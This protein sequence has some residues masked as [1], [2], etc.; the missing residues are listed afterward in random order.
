MVQFHHGGWVG[1]SF[2][3]VG[4][5]KRTYVGFMFIGGR[6]PTYVGFLLESTRKGQLIP[7]AVV[8][9]IWRSRIFHSNFFPLENP[10]PSDNQ[11]GGCTVQ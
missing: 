7:G 11:R 9:S 8:S 4:G 1:F 3:F 5:S 10:F 2:L 6:K